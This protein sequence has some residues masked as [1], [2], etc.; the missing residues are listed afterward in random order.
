M[1]ASDKI[2]KEKSPNIKTI[3]TKKPDSKK[4]SIKKEESFIPK[5]ICC[6]M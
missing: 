2:R 1:K 4:N 6:L 3:I 5:C